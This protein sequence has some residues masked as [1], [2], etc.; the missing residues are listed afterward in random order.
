L[1][2]SNLKSI[3]GKKFDDPLSQE[4]RRR[5]VNDMVVDTERNMPVFIHNGTSQLSIEEL[6]AYQFQN[7]KQQASAT[8]GE[9]VKDCVIT[10]SV[11]SDPSCIGSSPFVYC[12]VTPFA[13]QY[14]RQ[15]I[16]DAAD[17]AGLNVLT[18]MHDETAGKF[19]SSGVCM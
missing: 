1:T 15:A 14:E 8:A 10:V 6:I 16:L 4:F 11:L 18:L 12:K 13:N 3:I 5:Y 9:K 19:T 7:A 17:I 2:Y